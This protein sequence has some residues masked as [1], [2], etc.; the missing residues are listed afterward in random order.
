MSDLTTVIW[1]EWREFRAQGDDLGRGV[2]LAITCSLL[3]VAGATAALAGAEFVRSPLLLVV[4]ALPTIVVLGNVCDAFAGERERHTLETLLASRLSN[5]SL[6]AGKIAVN[7]LYGWAVAL[8]V[9]GWCVVGAN[10]PALGKTVTVPTINSTLTVLVVLPLGLVLG[11]TAGALV[12]LRA[13]SV[14]QASSRLVTLGMG[15]FFLLVPVPAAIRILVPTAVLDTYRMEA[16]RH[17]AIA[18]MAVLCATLAVAD[19]VVLAF[20]WLIFRRQRMIEVR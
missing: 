1:K 5:E 19:V 17:S 3:V 14:R 18:S 2:V 8:P 4:S 20:A 16:T 7:V 9:F 13:A 10:L 11:C 15:F 12:S 6:L